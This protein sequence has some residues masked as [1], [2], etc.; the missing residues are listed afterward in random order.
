M[1]AIG[2]PCAPLPFFGVEGKKNII[3]KTKQKKRTTHTRGQMLAIARAI[4]AGF[5][6]DD[7]LNVVL[8]V[9]PPRHRGHS[10]A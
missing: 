10:A 1:T 4:F 7:H 3:P 2:I 8:F 5:F 9:E 6:M